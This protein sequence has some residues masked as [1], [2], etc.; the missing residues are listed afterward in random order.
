M[1]G[2][3]GFPTHPLQTHRIGEKAL[4]DRELTLTLLERAVEKSRRKSTVQLPI[5]FV[6]EE[7]GMGANPPLARLLRGSPGRGGRSG[8]ARL[9]LYLTM[10]MRASAE[11]YDL[12]RY[13][14]SHNYAQMLGLD[15]PTQAGSRRISDALRWLAS[16][17]FIERIEGDTPPYPGFKVLNPL[18]AL[19]PSSHRAY[20]D[21]WVT[22]PLEVWTKGWIAQLSGRSLAL[23]IV[24]RELTGG[25]ADGG[26]TAD[27][28]RKTTYGLSPDTWTRATVELEDAGLLRTEYVYDDQDLGVI[29]RRRL[30]YYLRSDR[31][32]DLAW[33]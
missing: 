12:K 27:T 6:R 26:A 18:V 1:P 28:R 14:P 31:L 30:K 5:G 23:L 9:K 4:D 20:R 16:N 19:D 22:L 2:T 11:P 15:S 7:R 10:R 3:P 33:S 24:L 21:R 32:N 13:E 25:S 29:S 8:D 17:D